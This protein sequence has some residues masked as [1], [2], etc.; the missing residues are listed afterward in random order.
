MAS[1]AWCIER[2]EEATTRIQREAESQAARIIAS[3]DEFEPTSWSERIEH[4]RRYGH[5]GPERRPYSTWEL[6]RVIFPRLMKEL[7]A[8]DAGSP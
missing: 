7:D 1:I 6:R 3:M 5:D 8:L 2:L 4:R